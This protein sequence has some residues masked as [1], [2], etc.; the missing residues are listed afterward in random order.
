VE[1]AIPTPLAEALA[2][3][4]GTETAELRLELVLAGAPTAGTGAS[5]FSLAVR[6]GLGGTIP[7]VASFTASDLPLPPE[8]AFPDAG[9][10]VTSTMTIAWI[11]ALGSAGTGYFEVEV[12]KSGKSVWQIAVPPGESAG[13]P[14][15]IDLP[16]LPP[17][18]D[19]VFAPGDRLLLVVERNDVPGLVLDDF[20]FDAA[21]R[22]R[23]GRSVSSRAVSIAGGG[24]PGGGG[25]VIIIPEPG[26]SPGPAPGGP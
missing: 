15:G 13:D 20:T 9:A 3:A 1:I 26:P 10:Q 18:L 8:I 21:A 16:A 6:R 4:F 23:T 24:P 25:P 14:I 12:L 5:P 17:P 2:P 22:A 11:D 19:G 7:A